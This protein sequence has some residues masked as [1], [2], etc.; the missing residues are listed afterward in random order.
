MFYVLYCA[1]CGCRVQEEIDSQ[2]ECF[3]TLE[4][5]K[6]KQ[7]AATKKKTKI[8]IPCERNLYGRKIK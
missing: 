3:C 5:G 1:C 7:R 4:D 2:K 6:K 8:K